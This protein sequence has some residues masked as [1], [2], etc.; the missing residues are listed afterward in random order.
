ML[1]VLAFASAPVQ[2]HGRSYVAAS[3]SGVTC[4]DSKTLAHSLPNMMPFGNFIVQGIWAPILDPLVPDLGGSCFRGDHLVPS[5]QG[6]VTITIRDAVQPAVG[7]CVSQ[8]SDDD[9]DLC[10]DD[11]V[12]ARG[13]GSL[14]L[15]VDA[16]FPGAWRFA[17]AAAPRILWVVVNGLD[18][19]SAL[20][21][22]VNPDCGPGQNS[23]GTTGTI[24]H[25]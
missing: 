3:E 15:N 2:S 17:D 4:V 9:G 6:E 19:G 1:V 20:L 21:G 23:Y 24:E 5:A 8:D 11:E 12:N 16:P 7:F 22:P 18:D 10:D 14:T 25:R 13:C